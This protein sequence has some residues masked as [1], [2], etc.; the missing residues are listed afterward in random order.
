MAE[1]G[2]NSAPGRKVF[3]L[4]PSAVIQNQVIQELVQMEYEVYTVKDLDPFLPV[5]KKYPHSI[6]FADISE[7]M[8]EREWESWLRRTMSDSA[9]PGL[10]VGVISQSGNEALKAKYLG[11]VK[12]NCGYITLKTDLGLVIQQLLAALEAAKAKGDRKF[13]HLNTENEPNVTVN[14]PVNGIY[15]NGAIKDISAASF[16]CVFKEDPML[17]QNGL[18]QDIQLKLQSHLLKT[19]AV[20]LT[21]QQVGDDKQYVF[22]FTRRVDPDVRTRIRGYIQRC[23][24]AR[25]NAELA[26]AAR[27]DQEALDDLKPRP[28][29]AQKLS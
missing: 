24:Q 6:I 4:H 16:S 7:E 1:T 15:V 10:G 29:A 8:P 13:I 18:Y 3:F 28:P 5:L 22:V 25:M 9:F 17:R 19:E 26:K 11:Q 27:I 14:L 20:V 21:S 2:G 23:L 12:V